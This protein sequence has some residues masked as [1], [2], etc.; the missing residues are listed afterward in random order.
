MFQIYFM[1]SNNSKKEHCKHNQFK[2]KINIANY[3][4][5]N[6]KTGYDFEQVARQGKTNKLYL[7]FI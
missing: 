6:K 7:C 2:Q 4:F 5:N 3:I 1:R